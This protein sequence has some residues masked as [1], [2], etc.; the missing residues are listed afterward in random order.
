VTRY[1]R[2]TGWQIVA[3]A[4]SLAVS[5]VIAHYLW[6][7]PWQSVAERVFFQMVAIIL[8]AFSSSRKWDDG[9]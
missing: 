2:L 5:N 6:S 1:Y 3:L 9:E 7:V 8:L 4:I